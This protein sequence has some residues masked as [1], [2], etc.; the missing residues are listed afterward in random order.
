VADL[1][2]AV[3]GLQRADAR[4][5][6]APRFLALGQRPS[7]PGHSSCGAPRSPRRHR[8]VRVQRGGPDVQPAVSAVEGR[9]LSVHPQRAGPARLATTTVGRRAAPAVLLSTCP[10]GLRC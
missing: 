9:Q 10:F 5:K 6:A 1:V 4:A 8:P 3:G 2:N 7:G